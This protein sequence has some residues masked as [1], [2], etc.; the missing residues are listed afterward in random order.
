MNLRA[1][2]VGVI[3]FVALL[4]STP[5]VSQQAWDSVK[6]KWT[7]PGDDGTAG[8][9]S[10][11]DLRYATFAITAANFSTATRYTTITI[12]SVAGVTD[13]CTVTGL[14]P[15]TTYWFAIKT[16]D[17]VP[18]WATVSNI[19]TTTLPAAPDVSPPAAVTDFR[20][21]P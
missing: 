15:S 8:R 9:A 12:P 19:V 4:L 21:S 5:A 10:Q 18:N 2:G 20:V 16:A 7:A 6:L 14:T 11:Y 17:E 3:V 13:S 1:A